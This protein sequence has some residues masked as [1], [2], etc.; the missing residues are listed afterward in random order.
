[1][2]VTNNTGSPLVLPNGTEV[3]KGGYADVP[4]AEWSKMAG[5]PVVA[6]WLK[7]GLTADKPAAAAKPPKNNTAAGGASDAD[8]LLNG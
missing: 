7:N 4:D 3:P 6:H 1:M 8:K 5:H 2:K